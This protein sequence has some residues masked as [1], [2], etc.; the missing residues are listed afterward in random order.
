ML[1]VI[2]RLAAVGQRDC[3]PSAHPP[4]RTPITPRSAYSGPRGE[5][6]WKRWRSDDL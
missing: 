1:Y 3:H 4:A 5:L 2:E 6:P